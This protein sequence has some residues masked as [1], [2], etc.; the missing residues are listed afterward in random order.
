MGR[1]EVHFTSFHLTSL[2]FAETAQTRPKDPPS[3]E[4]SK[5]TPAPALTSPETQKQQ[6]GR[7]SGRAWNDGGL[8]AL[9][10][11]ENASVQELDGGVDRESPETRRVANKKTSRGKP[12]Y[13]NDEIA[14]IEDDGPESPVKKKGWGEERESKQPP[15]PKPPKLPPPR[16]EETYEDRPSTL[17]NSRSTKD[18]QVLTISRLGEKSPS[19]RKSDTDFGLDDSLGRLAPTGMGRPPPPGGNKGFKA[20]PSDKYDLDLSDD[21][22]EKRS[23]DMERCELISAY[24][25]QTYLSTDDRSLLSSVC[26][27]YKWNR[28]KPADLLDFL[29]RN[30]DAKQYSMLC[31]T[32]KDQDSIFAGFQGEN[33]AHGLFCRLEKLGMEYFGAMQT[34]YRPSRQNSYN[35]L[36]SFKVLGV[37]ILPGSEVPRPLVTLPDFQDFQIL[38]A[39]TKDPLIRQFVGKIITGTSPVQEFSSISFNQSQKAPSELPRR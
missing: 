34:L 4:S 13:V 6:F 5:A 11:D 38:K 22:D 15:L 3:D 12:G 7:T 17:L 25:P 27:Y 28:N 2:S 24:I 37:F 39:D 23:F 32:Y 31:F 9:R 19:N 36:D 26:R 20:A 30:F 33:V 16:R 1:G 10:V 14:T 18:E 8:Q 29:W 35:A 21:E